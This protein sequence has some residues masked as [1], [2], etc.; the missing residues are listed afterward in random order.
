[1]FMDELENV[2]RNVPY[3]VW[4]KV[5]GVTPDR[6]RVERLKDTYTQK[7][8]QIRVSVHSGITNYIVAGFERLD[9]RNEA[10]LRSWKPYRELVQKELDEYDRIMRLPTGFLDP[11][12]T[13]QEFDD[14]LDDI[15]KNSWFSRNQLACYIEHFHLKPVLKQKCYNGEM[16]DILKLT[17]N[18][19][20][21][22]KDIISEIVRAELNDEM[23]VSEIL[24]EYQIEPDEGMQK[25]LLELAGYLKDI[26]W[27]DTEFK[28][29]RLKHHLFR[30]LDQGKSV[31][32]IRKE[33]DRIVKDSLCECTDTEKEYC[34]LFGIDKAIRRRVF[35]LDEKLLDGWVI[36]GQ[37]YRAR[38]Y[39]QGMLQAVFG[40]LY[41]KDIS[42]ASFIEKRHLKTGDDEM[43]QRLMRR[44]EETREDF[45][46]EREKTFSDI[47]VNIKEKET[48]N[49]NTWY[50][51][52]LPEFNKIYYG[53]DR[54][55]TLGRAEESFRNGHEYWLMCRYLELSDEE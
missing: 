26:A 41:N 45:L 13:E 53:N 34:S 22:A 51:V 12:I 38:G 5:V 15:S 55:E 49:G 14:R 35:L 3:N 8:D 25:N 32:K 23:D 19:E 27:K 47:I 20:Q 39:R 9:M 11:V 29:E 1:M 42:L 33:A 6:V 50:E 10:L 17:Y 37:N 21:K 4:E 24:K 46:S 28:D 54:E 36:T 7:R 48:G 52:T 2:L 18:I 44:I 40:L 31:S 43:I 16:K 30:F